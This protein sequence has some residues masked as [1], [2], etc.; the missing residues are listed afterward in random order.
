[1]KNVIK[2]LIILLFF[3]LGYGIGEERTII[4]YTSNQTSTSSVEV[5]DSSKTISKT[6]RDYDNNLDL[7]M[8]WINNEY[9]YKDDIDEDEMKYGATYGLVQALGDPY[10][11]FL[12]PQVSKDFL[13]SM[14]GEFEGIGAALYMSEGLVTVEYTL[15]DSPA[16]EAGIKPDD[17]IYMVDG[18]IVTDLT[19]TEVVHMIRGD[20]GT[21]VDLTIIREGADKPLEIPVTRG[22]IDLKS[23]TWEMK[24]NNIAYIEINDFAEDTGSEFKETVSEVLLANPTGIILD[25]RYNSGG[26]FDQALKVL[27]E[28]IYDGVAVKRAYKDT[29][30]ELKVSGAARLANYPIVILTNHSTASASEIVA[31]ALRDYELAQLVGETTYGKGVIQDL[32]ELSDGASLKITTAKWLTPNDIWVTESPLEPDF[33][34]EITDED[35]EAERDTQLEKAIEIL[36][37][38]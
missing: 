36:S 34:V 14:E 23:V 22:M 17:I 26:Y 30:D 33:P 7:N 32:I 38:G 12:E 25:L 9:L 28:F 35:Y 24:D 5:A 8:F 15:K 11:V 13:G 6:I 10:S 16:M 2:V 20:R 18:E 19:L 4:E 3:L 37:Q 1:M 31:G 27:E 29:V 21:E